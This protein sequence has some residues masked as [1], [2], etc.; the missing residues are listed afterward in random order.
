MG[1][2]EYRTVDLATASEGRCTTDGEELN[3]FET[4]GPLHQGPT[5]EVEDLGRQ[6]S[7]PEIPHPNPSDRN[8]YIPIQYKSAPEPSKRFE[9]LI[10]SPD[11]PEPILQRISRARRELGF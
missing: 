5:G 8:D 2:R 6:C 3:T 10:F 9:A 4:A 11:P 7:S 1:Q